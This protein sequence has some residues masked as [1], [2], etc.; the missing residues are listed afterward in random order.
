MK[1]AVIHPNIASGFGGSEAV[2]LAIANALEELDHDIDYYS[3]NDVEDIA[4]KLGYDLPNAD[5][6]NLQSSTL[7]NFL[8]KTGRF[9]VLEQRVENRELLKQIKKIDADILFLTYGLLNS[10]TSIDPVTIQ[11]IHRPPRKLSEPKSLYQKLY[12]KFC[13]LYGE[14]ELLDADLTIFNSNF[15]RS[16]W[17]EEGQVIYP[18]VESD[19]KK[20]PWSEKSHKAIIV[21]RITKD[22]N[23]EEA[24][25]ICSKTSLKL[26]IAGITEDHQ[27]LRQLE[28][29]YSGDDWIEIKTDLSRGAL[30]EE[31]QDSKI[32]L[33]CKRKEHFGIAVVEYLKAGALPM[34]RNE[35]GPREIVPTEKMTYSTIDEAV[36]NIDYLCRSPEAFQEL[37]A[38]RAEDFSKEKFKEEIKKTVENYS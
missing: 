33:L 32:G 1:S 20:V 38:N 10:G 18:P 4:N 35:G 11:Y 29:K 13:A 5:F 36:K 15:T 7:A 30:K 27:Y 34:V 19:F 17:D 16:C 14:N 31:I 25:E 21:G 3:N 28:E 9:T 6:K 26:T 22:K 24:V 2:S 8:E 37:G 12:R 23:I